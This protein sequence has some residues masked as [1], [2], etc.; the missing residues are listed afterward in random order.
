LNNVEDIIIPVEI[1]NAVQSDFTQ[2]K[3]SNKI[4]QSKVIG[5]LDVSRIM[6]ESPTVK[7]MQNIIDQ[8][9]RE[10]S[11]QLLIERSSLSAEEFKQRQQAIY[12][13]FMELKGNL[14]KQ[15]DESI[16]QV[17]AAIKKEKN[18]DFVIFKNT[19]KENIPL[20]SVDITSDV[21]DRMEVI[22]Q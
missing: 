9:G 4:L 21:I 6:S 1:Q 8:K 2:G 22:K 18:L 3:S 17:T 20:N 7:A 13:E 5:Y 11:N 10:L 15:I 14:E 19:G 12:Q 16:K